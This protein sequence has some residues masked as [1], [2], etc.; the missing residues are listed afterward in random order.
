VTRSLLCAVLVLILAVLVDCAVAASDAVPLPVDLE[1]Q[2]FRYLDSPDTD[3]AA[4]ALQS[5][6]SDPNI[7][8]D[9]AVRI[10]PTERA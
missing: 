6:L 9:Q 3:E 10:I 2:I 4:R 8:I 7:T 5:M 1:T